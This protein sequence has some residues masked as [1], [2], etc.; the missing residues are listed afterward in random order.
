[1]SVFCNMAPTHNLNSVSDIHHP[2]HSTCLKMNQDSSENMRHSNTLQSVLLGEIPSAY[3]HLTSSHRT[4]LQNCRDSEKEPNVPFI[5][6]QR[7]HEH[8]YR[9]YQCSSPMRAVQN[10]SP[11]SHLVSRSPKRTHS[12]LTDRHSNYSNGSYYQEA[13]QYN[14]H[15]YDRASP[16]YEGRSS[17]FQESGSPFIGSS[18]HYNSPSRSFSPSQSVGS[19]YSVH[20]NDGSP[21]S[22]RHTSSPYQSH[23]AI[24]P[25]SSSR[26]A[27]SPYNI[28]ENSNSPYSGSQ[29]AYD[30]HSPVNH[31]EGY[32]IENHE[33]FEDQPI[34]L[35]RKS[36]AKDGPLFASEEGELHENSGNGS[37][38]RT[39][40]RPGKQMNTDYNSDSGRD[41]PGS[42][43]FRPDIP[44][45]GSTRVT[46]AK[47]MVYP[48]TSRVSDWLVKIV[49][50]SKSIPEFQSM[51]QN[52][53][54]TLLL[55]SWTRMLL[56]LMAENDC[57]FAVTPLH[58]D[59]KQSDDV[60]PCQ[61]EPTMKSVEGIQS[62][63]R[64]CKNMGMDQKEYALMR[65]A[66]LFNS[67]NVGLDDAELVE[68][69]NSAV[70]QLLQQHVT[71]TRPN[72][73]M[74]Y[75]RILM[76]LPSLYGINCRMVETLFCKRINTDMQVLLK[77]MLQNL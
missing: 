6:V 51:S 3:L 16:A 19:P 58:R 69:L 10:S 28:Y 38:L 55:N 5:H 12:P 20:R 60:T 48:I 1:M 44:V 72:D 46:L 15:I 39:L 11:Q 74:H 40:L 66:V 71:S 17:P 53:K 75:S 30:I 76:L 31:S 14:G 67:G 62:F 36:E 27:N 59:E 68:K 42:D 61:D 56:L 52:D 29:S 22:P 43:V 37:L 65:M 63:T 47:K 9:P 64:K 23:R 7:E 34:D 57:E 8:S 26:I 49:Q 25:Y 35:S 45:T 21:Y 33:N 13:P 77:E 54:M 4:P 70:Q 50:F 41:S 2:I 73:V 24:S 32:S 18:P